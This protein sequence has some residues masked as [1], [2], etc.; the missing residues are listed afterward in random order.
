MAEKKERIYLMA[1][2]ISNGI[3]T[4]IDEDGTIVNYR[5]RG[6]QRLSEEQQKLLIA[7]GMLNVRWK[8]YKELP[9][10]ISIYYEDEYIMG[11]ARATF[12]T[13]LITKFEITPEI[14]KKYLKK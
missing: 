5:Q 13:E 8:S 7:M 3:I 11:K 9:K 2:S 10:H 6:I 4:L 1:V 12:P 14:R